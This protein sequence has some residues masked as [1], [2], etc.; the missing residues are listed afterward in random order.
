M[1]LEAVRHLKSTM[2][3]F[4]VESQRWV[5]DVKPEMLSLNAQSLILNLKR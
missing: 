3:S 1:S 2:L 5:S 4:N